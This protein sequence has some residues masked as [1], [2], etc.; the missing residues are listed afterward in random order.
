MKKELNL[1]MMKRLLVMKKYFN[2]VFWIWNIFSLLKRHFKT[3]QLDVDKVFRCLTLFRFSLSFINNEQTT[4]KIKGD[5]GSSTCEIGRWSTSRSEGLLRS[6]LRRYRNLENI[7]SFHFIYFFIKNRL[8]AIWKHDFDTLLWYATKNTDC[9]YYYF[10]KQF[11]FLFLHSRRWISVWH[12]SKFWQP[13][14]IW[15]RFDCTFLN[16]YFVDCFLFADEALNQVYNNNNTFFIFQI[17]FFLVDRFEAI[18][19]I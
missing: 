10:L 2:F 16:K 9:C 1:S 4:R 13:M 12:R 19:A 8:L 15:I 17:L 5:V 11:L 14:V 18:G 6:R 7:F 3:E